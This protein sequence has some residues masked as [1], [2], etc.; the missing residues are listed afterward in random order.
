[1]TPAAYTAGVVYLACLLA[2]AF[3]AALLCTAWLVHSEARRARA[4]AERYLTSARREYA[5][6]R[7]AREWADATGGQ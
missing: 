3:S 7:S 2:L 6:A 5:T 4:R 1:M